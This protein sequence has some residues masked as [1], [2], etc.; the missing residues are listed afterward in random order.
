MVHASKPAAPW[1]AAISPYQIVRCRA[2][3]YDSG[4]AGFTGA[5]TGGIALFA[6]VVN[7]ESAETE[8]ELSVFGAGASGLVDSIA[9]AEPAD[10][11]FFSAVAEGVAGILGAPVGTALQQKSTNAE[12]TKDHLSDCRPGEGGSGRLQRSVNYCT[13]GQV[14]LDLRSR[15]SSTFP[16]LSALLAPVPPAFFRTAIIRPDSISVPS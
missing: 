4:V 1:A 14:S 15:A 13:T 11:P 2:V 7:S 12:R 5:L 16:A 9:E 10:A 6:A 3:S 8:D